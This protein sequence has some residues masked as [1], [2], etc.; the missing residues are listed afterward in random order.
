MAQIQ[1]ITRLRFHPMWQPTTRFMHCRAPVN[2][3]SGWA[4]VETLQSFLELLWRTTLRKLNGNLWN[5]DSRFKEARE[6]IKVLHTPLS[7]LIHKGGHFLVEQSSSPQSISSFQTPLLIQVF[8]SPMPPIFGS[9]STLPMS[10]TFLTSTLMSPDRPSDVL[11][12]P[13]EPGQNAL[14]LFLQSSK[15]PVAPIQNTR[16]LS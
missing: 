5:A 1:E 8:P 14:S 11:I 3:P 16:T 7:H 2:M 12:P 13:T 4:K 9:V 15:N 6:E 10:S